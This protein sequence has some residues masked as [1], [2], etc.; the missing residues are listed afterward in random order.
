VALSVGRQP[1]FV[2]KPKLQLGNGVTRC[3]DGDAAFAGLV[4]EHGVGTHPQRLTA[5]FQGSSASRIA[6]ISSVE[7]A[8]VP[9]IRRQKTPVARR[10]RR[11]IASI[12]ISAT[13]SVLA[14]VTRDKENDAWKMY[15][16]VEQWKPKQTR[17]PERSRI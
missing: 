12:R 2:R 4:G 5:T 10:R 3:A 9:S 16:A 6:S 8:P 1:C 7:N 17:L 14:L 15:G 11:T 13:I